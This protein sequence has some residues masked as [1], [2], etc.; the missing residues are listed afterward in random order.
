MA[1]GLGGGLADED[2]I[3]LVVNMYKDLKKKENTG[4]RNREIEKIKKK[5]L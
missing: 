5:K 3:N 1:R 4:N 2:F